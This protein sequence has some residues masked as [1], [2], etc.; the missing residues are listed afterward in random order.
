MSS[1]NSGASIV[2]L[3]SVSSSLHTLP[4]ATSIHNVHIHQHMYAQRAAESEAK[5]CPSYFL[6]WY[7]ILNILQLQ[8]ALSKTASAASQNQLPL[9]Q[10]PSPVSTILV[11]SAFAVLSPDIAFLVPLKFFRR[12]FH[13]HYKNS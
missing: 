10:P 13:R 1:K 6:L 4:N 8:K 9:Y 12:F 2:A 5:A 7:N 3:P 11:A